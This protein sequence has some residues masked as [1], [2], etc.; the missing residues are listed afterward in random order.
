MAAK[1]KR[2]HSLP[3]W[4]EGFPSPAFGK[5][6]RPLGLVAVTFADMEQMLTMSLSELLHRP[7]EEAMAIEWLMQSLTNRI[8]LFY[9]L[10]TE[11]TQKLVKANEDNKATKAAYES[12]GDAASDIYEALMQAQTDR[13]NLMHSAWTGIGVSKERSYS[14]DRYSAGGGKLTE[15]PISGVTPTILAAEAKY[16]VSLHMRLWDWTMRATRGS[17]PGDW[18]A[19]LHKRYF[20]RS[21]LHSL[22]EA[23]RNKARK[24]QL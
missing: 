22:I 16:F 18:P 24:R 6:Y 21:P 1:R 2:S 13:N 4:R 17:G 3:R 9:F 23:N 19:P 5:L 8:Q 7:Y 12:L 10:A 15:I 14:K 11:T 20:L